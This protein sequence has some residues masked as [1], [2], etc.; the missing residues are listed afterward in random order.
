MNWKL[1]YPVTLTDGSATG[2]YRFGEK[3]ELKGLPRVSRADV[4]DLLLKLISDTRSI[5][6]DLLVSN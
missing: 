4:A 5:R 6:R 2:R 3:I 1:I